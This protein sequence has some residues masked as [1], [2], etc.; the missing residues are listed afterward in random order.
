MEGVLLGSATSILSIL[1]V[2]LWKRGLSICRLMLV[3]LKVA[4]LSCLLIK[5]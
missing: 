1:A 4:I 3:S 2:W 5:L